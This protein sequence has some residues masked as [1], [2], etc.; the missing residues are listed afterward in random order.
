M[1][2]YIPEWQTPAISGPIQIFLSKSSLFREFQDSEPPDN[3]ITVKTGF[4][5]FLHFLPIHIF[6]KLPVEQQKERKR[7]LAKRL[8]EINA[9]KREERL[10]EDQE[11][12]RQLLEINEIIEFGAEKD[13][14][15]NLLLEYQLK[16]V[17][18]LQKNIA[19]L[20]IKIEKTKQKISAASTIE[21]VEEPPVK[22]TK[23][24][25]MV[26]ENETALQSFLENVKKMVS[27]HI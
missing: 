13:E 10:A 20:N 1:L 19:N 7:E 11:K 8:T 4:N 3:T 22:Q 16:N 15:E 5:D 27:N 23:L 21:D 25:K 18:E 6:F 9:R 2:V 12:L 17:Q 26:F 24:S 14:I